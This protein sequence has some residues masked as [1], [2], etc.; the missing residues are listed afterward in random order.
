[1]VRCSLRFQDDMAMYQA[2]SEGNYKV[3]KF[4][5]SART[6]SARLSAN[7]RNEFGSKV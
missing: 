1:M 6:M 4:N 5:N 7:S 3:Y 2:R